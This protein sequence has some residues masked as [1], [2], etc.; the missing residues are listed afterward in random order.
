MSKPV[1][2]LLAADILIELTDQPDRPFV[3]IERAYPPYGWAVPGGFVDVGETVEQAA[4]REAK[5]ETCL[6]ITLTVLLGI[7]S[8]P[9]RDPRNHTVTAVYIAEATG[10]PLAA[11]DA[12][13][14][15]IFTFANLPAVLAF[16][17]AQVVDDYKNYRMTGKV[18]PLRV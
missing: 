11:D 9:K 17:H 5:E 6:D 14:F 10:M 2:P 12:K 1:T 4:I 15:G 8:N 16:D 3:L 7:Y 13:N 18:T